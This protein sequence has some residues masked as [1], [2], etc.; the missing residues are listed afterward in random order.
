MSL[1]MWG[2]KKSQAESHYGAS[3]SEDKKKAALDV[4]ETR[5]CNL[6]NFQQQV[7]Q[8]KDNRFHFRIRD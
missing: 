7:K 4:K 2:L 5:T 6:L 8:Q 1:N 3:N